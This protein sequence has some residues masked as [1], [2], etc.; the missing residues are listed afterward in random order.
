LGRP[1]AQLMTWL[2]EW[3]NSLNGA[4]AVILGVILGLMMCF[5]LGGPVN[6]VAYT[7]ATTGLAAAT[8]SQP[9][10][11]PYLIMAAVMA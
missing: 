5:D 8:A 11:S 6:K 1:I 9:F 4:S 10:S 2:T 7:F 3:L